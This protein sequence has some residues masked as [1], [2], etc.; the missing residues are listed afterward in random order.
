MMNQGAF[1]IAVV[2][3][4]ILACMGLEMLLGELIPMAEIVTCESFEELLSKDETE[5]VHYFVSSRVY[6]EHTAYFR[7]KKGRSIVMVSGDMSI[8]GVV[9]LNVCQ[10][11]AELISDLLALHRRGH[12][13]AQMSHK[14]PEGIA[15]FAPCGGQMQNILSSREI[16][17]A[18]LLCQ[19]YINKEVADKL[20]ISLTT[21]ITHRKNIMEKLGGRSL[22][23]V[24]VYCVM[25]GVYSV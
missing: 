4:N 21:V 15:G 1:R 7:A 25:N 13:G 11:R 12:E 5:F 22:A 24:I 18:L 6:F 10:S 16:E 17:V 8:S 23:D 2:D 14:G 3:A 19:G 20:N 9:T